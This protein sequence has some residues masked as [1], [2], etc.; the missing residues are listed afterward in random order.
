MSIN[1]AVLVGRL[2]RD[3]EVRKTQN[4]LSVCSFTLACDRNIAK[5]DQSD[6]QQLADFISCV[7]WRQSADF[8]GQYAHKGTM[9]GIDGRIQTRNYERQ[10]GT[11]VYVTEV[12]ADNVQ[13]L[14]SKKTTSNDYPHNG[15]SVNAEDIDHKI[16]SDPDD[17]FNQQSENKPAYQQQTA[18]RMG[19]DSDND[20]VIDQDDLPF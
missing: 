10:D 13:L 2:T 15:T 3:P 19:W 7:A 20:P 16:A 1:R 17:P 18:D 6:S 4:G 11:K 14:E 12:V 9:I 5:K 8:L